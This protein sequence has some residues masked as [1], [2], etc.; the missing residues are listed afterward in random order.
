[1]KEEILQKIKDSKNNPATGRN[2]M[3]CP[4]SMYDP[5]FMISSRFNESDLKE[6]EEVTLQRL[7]DLA[8]FAS[9][10]FY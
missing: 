1:M 7:V 2:S 10:V 4:E 6:M 9:E 5:Y 3:G 8:E